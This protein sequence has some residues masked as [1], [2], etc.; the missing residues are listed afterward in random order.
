MWDQRYDT[1]EYIYGTQPN[2]FLVEHI[3]AAKTGNALCLA[4]GEGRNAAWLAEQGFTVTA[5][6]AS[7]VGLRK[8]QALAQKRGVA[9]QTVVADLA[10][11]GIEP[12]NWS[13]IVSIF[14]HL[15]PQ[16]RKALYKKVAAGLRPGGTFILQA[17]TPQQLKYGTGGPP[18]KE[19]LVT[20]QDLRQEL[21]GLDFIK[22]E[23]TV[24]KVNEG[25]LHNG[26]AAVVQIVAVKPQTA[27]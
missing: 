1:R 16:V 26:T 15:P 20:L 8:A 19:L 12:E 14:C 7:A 25:R 10:T 2:Q 21:P 18:L 6:D 23:E 9:I 5:V 17:Y 13:L 27:A 3:D 22:A 4:A 24:R 11:Y